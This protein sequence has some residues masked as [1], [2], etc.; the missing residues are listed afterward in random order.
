LQEL[1]Y[2]LW[3]DVTDQ[4]SFDTSEELPTDFMSML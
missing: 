3:Q 2:W 1:D 4:V